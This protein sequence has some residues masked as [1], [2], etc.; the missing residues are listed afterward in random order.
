MLEYS[1]GKS[2]SMQML[3]FETDLGGRQLE[4]VNR[5]LERLGE[6]TDADALPCLWK[7]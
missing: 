4:R 2:Q 1:Q 7:I 6:I 5:Q 3:P